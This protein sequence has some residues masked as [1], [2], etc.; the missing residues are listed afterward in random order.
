MTYAYG[1]DMNSP[2]AD[3]FETIE[4]ALT[5]AEQEKRDDGETGVN[6]VLIGE[7]TQ[8][9]TLLSDDVYYYAE[10]ILERVNNSLV[11]EMDSEETAFDL[12]DERMRELG[13]LIHD[14]V[15]EYGIFTGAVVTNIKTY[16]MNLGDAA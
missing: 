7:V 8:A 10:T 12:T 5:A 3:A 15:L 4:E 9:K 13:K 6:E 14:F 11:F 16:K 1:F 2:F